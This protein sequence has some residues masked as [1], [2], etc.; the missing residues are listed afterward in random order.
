MRRTVL[1]LV[2]AATCV[3]APT[4]RADG[5]PASDYLYAAKVFLPYDAKFPKAEARKFTA[6]VQSVNKAGFKIRVAVIW[7]SYDMGSVTSL[8]GKP[9]TYAK[10]L[11]I[12]LS[13]VY[14]QRLLIVEPAGFGFNW[15]K[16][17][18]TSEDALLARIPVGPGSAGLL[19]AAQ[20]AVTKLAAASGYTPS[21]A[22]GAPAQQPSTNHDR[23]VILAAVLGA[24]ALA[25]AARFALRR[26][27][28]P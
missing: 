17:T 10:F 24:F 8:Y 18:T 28:S 19:A 27:R 14:K 12:E 23:I 13:F 5:D 21:T 2:L 6:L 7:S 4:A 25:V 20:E 9:K 3:A 11:G 1:L 22:A 16:H 15:P 26:R